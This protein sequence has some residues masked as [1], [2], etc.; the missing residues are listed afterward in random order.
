M[1]DPYGLKKICTAVKRNWLM[2]IK[3]G[4]IL[5]KHFIMK[6]H[7]TEVNDTYALLHF[8]LETSELL[9]IQ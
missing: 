8:L 7:T 3:L 4:K 2:Q 9:S 5:R 6:Q 1:N